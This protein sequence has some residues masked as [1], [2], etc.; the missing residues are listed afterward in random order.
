MK[1]RKKQILYFLFGK[2][3]VLN[4]KEKRNIENKNKKIIL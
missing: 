3:K 4:Y 2:T 1:N